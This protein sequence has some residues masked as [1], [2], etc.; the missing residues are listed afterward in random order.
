MVGVT[1]QKTD[2]GMFFTSCTMKEIKEYWETNKRSLRWC[3]VYDEEGS[4]WFWHEGHKYWTHFDRIDDKLKSVYRRLLFK[5][6]MEAIT[7]GV[8]MEYVSSLNNQN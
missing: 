2:G 5:Y 7:N 6:N 4:T 3:I 1:F 8:V